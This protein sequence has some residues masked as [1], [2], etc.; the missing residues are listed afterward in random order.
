MEHARS[1]HRREWCGCYRRDLSFGLYLIGYKYWN[2]NASQLQTLSFMAI[3]CGGNLTIYLTR[4][5]GLVWMK[6]LPE[7][8][9]ML[10][11][12]FSLAIGTLASVYG[13]WTKDFIGIGWAYVGWSWLYIAIWFVILMF[14][15][16]GI[17]KMLGHQNEYHVS[18]LE[19]QVNKH[20][21]V[22]L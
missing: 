11:T 21:Q 10:A 13:L 12:L 20:M 15:K 2:M 8:K 14:V 16:A 22:G 5:T 1:S 3:L 6:P 17:Y 18:Y 7:V 9:F 4:N 19:K